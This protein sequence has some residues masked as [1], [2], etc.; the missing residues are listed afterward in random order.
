MTFG[1]DMNEGVTIE[2]AEKEYISHWRLNVFPGDKSLYYINGHK[3]ML[4][5]LYQ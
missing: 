2:A 5:V 3:Y 1:L 4:H